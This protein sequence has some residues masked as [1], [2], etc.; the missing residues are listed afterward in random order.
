MGKRF[1]IKSHLSGFSV[2][3][4]SLIVSSGVAPVSSVAL[5]GLTNFHSRSRPEPSVLIWRLQIGTIASSKVAFTARSPN[6]FHSTAG[7]SLLDEF[8]FLQYN[9]MIIKSSFFLKWIFTWGVSSDTASM[10]CLLQIFLASNQSTSKLRVGW[11]SQ[12]KKY[13]WATPRASKHKHFIYF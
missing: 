3:W 6:E 8:V 1:Q 5:R 10:Q 2:V 9:S 13:E 12:L 11:C 4:L 7:H